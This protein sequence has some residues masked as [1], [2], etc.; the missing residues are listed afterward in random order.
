MQ[1]A[2]AANIDGKPRMLPC[3]FLLKP[4]RKNPVVLPADGLFY[5]GRYR[6]AELALGRRKRHW[7][8][9]PWCPT[10]PTAYD[11]STCWSVRR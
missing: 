5:Q 8:R 9:A 1:D 7:R 2:R 4:R 11:I 3:G 6:L 10:P